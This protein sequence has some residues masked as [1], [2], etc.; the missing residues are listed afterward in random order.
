M[1]VSG[2]IN[3]DRIRYVL[4]QSTDS[5]HRIFFAKILILKLPRN[6]GRLFVAIIGKLFYLSLYKI[7]LKAS[8][9]VGSTWLVTK[10]RCL[11][12]FTLDAAVCVFHNGQ[13]RF[14]RQMQKFSGLV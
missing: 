1:Y 11:G 3:Y 7:T 10:I 2:G 13:K 5:K 8:L 14:C 6:L 9:K 4:R 12:W